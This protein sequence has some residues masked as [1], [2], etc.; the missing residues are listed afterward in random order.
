[1]PGGAAN[2]IGGKA[3]IVRIV[4]PV[5][6]AEDVAIDFEL[7]FAV[8]QRLGPGHQKAGYILIL[9]KYRLACPRIFDEQ[10]SLHWSERFVEHHTAALQHLDGGGASLFV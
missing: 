4:S 6:D 5:A 9:K 7:G 1:M 8:L 3:G 2:G 10:V